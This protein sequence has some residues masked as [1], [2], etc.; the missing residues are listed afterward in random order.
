MLGLDLLPE[1]LQ[2]Q[3]IMPSE[4]ALKIPEVFEAIDCLAQIDVAVSGA[5]GIVR[6]PNGHKGHPPPPY[7]VLILR[8]PARTTSQPWSEH[9]RDCSRA[10]KA[11]IVS[12]Q[13]DWNTSPLSQ[14]MELYFCLSVRT[15]SRQASDSV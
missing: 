3:S 6:Y 5:E 2:A 15:E 9:V 13:A 7:S 11:E 10:L 8:A 4:I 12:T 14:Q 1:S